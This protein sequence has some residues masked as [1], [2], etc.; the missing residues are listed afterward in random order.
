M[1]PIHIM[2]GERPFVYCIYKDENGNFVGGL[3]SCLG[4]YREWCPG[5][6]ELS[7]QKP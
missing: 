7:Q 4:S 3:G 2:F 6:A 5:F 1:G